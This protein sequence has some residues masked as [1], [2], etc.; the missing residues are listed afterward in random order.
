MAPGSRPASITQP[1]RSSMVSRY[2]AGLLP[3]SV[4]LLSTPAWGAT[5]C[6]ADIEKFCAKVPVGGGRIQACLKE[7]EKE[8]SAGC[9]ARREGLEKEIGALAATCRWD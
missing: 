4:A 7:H 2:L 5:P 9:A 1:R 6:A 3:L 8:L